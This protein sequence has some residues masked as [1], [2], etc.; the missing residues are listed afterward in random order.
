MDERQEDPWPALPPLGLSAREQRER[1]RE[2]RIHAHIRKHRERG[3]QP[4]PRDR[5][6]TREEIVSTAMAVADAEGVEAI[7]MR[8]IARELGAGVMSLYWHVASKEEL[9]DL[10]LESVEAEIQLPEPSGDW[11]ADMR[12]FARN[13]RAALLRHQWAVD[14]RGFRPPSGPNDARNAERVFAIL[15]GLGLD[16]RMTVMVT[17]AV[18]TYVIGAVLRETQ[19]MRFQRETE[20]AMAGMTAEEIVALREEFAQRVLSSGQYPHIACFIEEDVDPDSPDTRDERFEFGLDC[21][22]DG[23]GARLP[24]PRPLD[25]T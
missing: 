19:E 11:R 24:A 14:F 17:M 15:D 20:Q 9:Q 7:S 12:T 8:R 4:R 3:A 2:N 21:I 25:R 16:G 10:M 1:E 13:T 22:L 23:I 5:G 6:L 18:G